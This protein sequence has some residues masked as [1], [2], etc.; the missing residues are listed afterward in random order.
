[1]D[2]FSNYRPDSNGYGIRGMEQTIYGTEGFTRETDRIMFKDDRGSH[3]FT[4]GEFR[5]VRSEL[6]EKLADTFRRTAK[7]KYASA[8]KSLEPMEGAITKEKVPVLWEAMQSDLVRGLFLAD[9]KRKETRRDYYPSMDEISVLGRAFEK[10]LR[11]CCV[12]M[13]ARTSENNNVPSIRVLTD[14][15]PSWIDI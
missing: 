11:A 15:P 7:E 6:E 4:P 1:R 3:L 12:Q 13:G 14:T 5:K 10:G 8:L 2:F 9:I